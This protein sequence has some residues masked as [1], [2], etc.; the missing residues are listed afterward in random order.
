MAT[1]FTSDWHFGHFTN[2]ERGVIQFCGRPFPAKPGTP[3]MNK[4]IIEGFKI[5]TPEDT[6]YVLGD[7]FFR[8]S[9]EEAKW[10][11]DQIPCKVILIRGNHDKW[12]K[13]KMLRVGFDEV[14]NHEVIN[15]P[16]GIDIL[17]IHDPVVAC[18]EKIQ[19]HVILCGHVHQ[20]W[21]TFGRCINVGVDVWDFKPV[22]LEALGPLILEAK[23]Q[24]WN[25]YHDNEQREKYR[26]ARKNG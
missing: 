10:I 4:K 3:E 19:E 15:L 22:S 21:R 25:E 8:T 7:C 17:L 13:A 24:D 5:L 12:G 1:Y 26:S 11:L 6:L 18:I 9:P 14:L 20:L 2:R 16:E 23:E